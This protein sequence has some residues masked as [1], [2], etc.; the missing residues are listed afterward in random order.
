MKN[1]K[2]DFC[3][4]FFVIGLLIYI[5]IMLLSIGPALNQHEEIQIVILGNSIFLLIVIA[6]TMKYYTVYRKE[7]A[8]HQNKIK[9]FEE[10]RI[11]IKEQLDSFISKES[12]KISQSLGEENSSPES[13]IPELNKLCPFCGEIIDKDSD[14]CSH[15][16]A[17]L[18]AA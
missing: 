10:S 5:D 14:T 12:S 18:N 1:K 15:C 7:K 8:D 13:Q 3:G 16:G 9:K 2:G 4:L 6:I 11:K 17:N